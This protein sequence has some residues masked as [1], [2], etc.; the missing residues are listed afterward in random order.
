MPRIK[1][2]SLEEHHELVWKDIT[3]AVGELLAERDYD[4]INLGHIAARAG[5]ARNTLYNYAD[6]KASLVIAIAER[7]SRPVLDRVTAIADGSG[8]ATDRA[9]A[10]ID[11][12]MNAFADNTIRLMLPTAAAAVSAVSAVSAE[13][14]ENREGPF[15]AVARSMEKVVRDGIARGEFR[16]TDDVQLTTWLLSGIVRAGVE[17]MVRDQISPTDMSGPVQDLIIGALTAAPSSM[18]STA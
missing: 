5:L 7:A 3:N 12:L 9:R 11:E 15:G 10:I 2:A 17:R 16:P 8:P 18:P 14:V 13:V 6:D 4:S 1:A